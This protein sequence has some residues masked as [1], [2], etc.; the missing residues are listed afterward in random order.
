VT[1][2]PHVNGPPHDLRTGDELID[3]VLDTIAASIRALESRTDDLL[4]HE[5]A[6]LA[7]VTGDYLPE[8]LADYQRMPG[9]WRAAE[10]PEG[11]TPRDAAVE[12]VATMAALLTAAEERLHRLSAARLVVGRD[13]MKERLDYA[14]ARSDVRPIVLIPHAPP[15]PVTW[16]RNALIGAAVLTV[17]LFG[18]GAVAWCVAALISIGHAR[19]SAGPGGLGVG[20]GFFFVLLVV[21]V[22]W[23][24]A[25]SK[26]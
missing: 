6:T 24:M 25:G 4:D 26:R 16:P 15:P 7:Q 5:R 11:G 8:L 17:V 14:A 3:S 22:L 19:Q 2:I 13:A 23:A 18:F 12:A 21:G 1:S 9:R 10:T 20:G